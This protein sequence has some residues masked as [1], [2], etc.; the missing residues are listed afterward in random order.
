M[1]VPIVPDIVTVPDLGVLPLFPAL[2][3]IAT[4][5]GPLDDVGAVEIQDRLSEDV[6][7]QPVTVVTETEPEP[8]A[9]GNADGQAPKV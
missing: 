4:D 2:T 7:V 8:P 5:P 1:V 3:V 9:R 6:H